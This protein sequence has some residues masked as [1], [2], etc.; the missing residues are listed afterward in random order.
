MWVKICGIQT[1][2]TAVCCAEAGADAVGFVF[3]ESRRK[4]SVEKAAEIIRILPPG[5]DKVGVF[6]NN[7]YSDVAAIDDY[8]DLDLLQFHGDESPQYCRIFPGRTLKSFRLTN[9]ADLKEVK[10]YRGS[11]KACLLDSFEV[12]QLG[13]TGKAWNWSMLSRRASQEKYLSGLNL[14]VAGG[15]TA[16]NVKVALNHLSPYGVDVSS[17]VEV[18]GQKDCGFIRDF[19]NTVRSW[20]N[21][22]SA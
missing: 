11:V 7:S 15:L 1:V 12:G 13:G 2:E 20:E 4:I 19:I 21:E 9:P 10:R 6:V 3:A 16:E 14:V 8:L 17:G 5:I 22:Q 18:N